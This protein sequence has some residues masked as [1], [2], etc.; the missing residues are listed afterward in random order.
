MVHRFPPTVVAASQLVS[1]PRTRGARVDDALVP[2]VREDGE[3]DVHDEQDDAKAWSEKCVR[4]ARKIPVGPCIPVGVRLYKAELAQLLGQLGVFLTRV[5][6][7]SEEGE[8]ANHAE[9]D[10]DQADDED[11]IPHPETFSAAIQ[12]PHSSAKGWTM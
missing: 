1:T 8:G 5:Q 10:D 4:L 6:P 7:E 3:D 9:E 12:P 11:L 2:Q